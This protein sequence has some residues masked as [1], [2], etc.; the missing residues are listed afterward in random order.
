AIIAAPVLTETKVQ[1]D[2]RHFWFELLGSSQ[3]RDCPVPFLAPH[4][5]HA[6]IGISGARAPVNRKHLTKGRFCGIEVP[7]LKRRLPFRKQCL[8]I[9]GLL[10]TR[11]RRTGLRLY[12]ISRCRSR[13][14]GP[15]GNQRETDRQNVFLFLASPVICAHCHSVSASP[16][17]ISRRLCALALRNSL[18]STDSAAVPALARIGLNLSLDTNP[19]MHY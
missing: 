16:R 8:R 6:K 11:R 12:A 15:G 7:R 18:Y 17:G 10:D 3:Q 9:H 14:N 1:P 13:T 4:S 5:D 2:P 19:Q